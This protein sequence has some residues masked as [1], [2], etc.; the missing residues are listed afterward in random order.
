MKII[1]SHAHFWS[2]SKFKY[3]WIQSGSPFDRDFSLEDY[4]VASQDIAIE[5]MVF[6]ECDCNPE[7]SFDEVAWVE[8]YAMIDKRIQGIVAHL[9]LTDTNLNA[10]ETDIEKMASNNLVKGIRHNIQ[11]SAPGFAL[12]KSF[13][14]GVQLVQKY[15][16]HFELCLTHDQ[17][18][19]VIAL[20]KQCPN[21]RFVLDHCAKPGIKAGLKEPWITHMKQMAEFENVT[22]KI[23]GLLT[24]ADWKAWKMEEILF[25]ADHATRAF[26]T[27]RIMFGSDWPVNE[28]A[29]GYAQWFAVTQMLTKEW[30]EAERSDFYF[31]NAQV[32][33]RLH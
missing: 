9:H 5:K 17:M 26:G 14:T 7:H 16:L 12:Q 15:N 23:S 19:E 30:S 27:K 8:S 29:G 11:N 22:C 21:A 1:D 4:Q 20:V 3:P 24:E 25:Y 33:Y 6:V 13:I 28:V 32:F 31:N 10:V 2:V 18:D